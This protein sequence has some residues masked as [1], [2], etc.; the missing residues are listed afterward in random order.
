MERGEK[1]IAFTVRSIWSFNVISTERPNPN[2][3][4]WIVRYS[5]LDNFNV[6]LPDDVCRGL[7]ASE[8]FE[9]NLWPGFPFLGT[10]VLSS[11]S[12]TDTFVPPP[13]PNPP[14]DGNGIQT[15]TIDHVKRTHSISIPYLGNSVAYSNIVYQRNQ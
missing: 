4:R 7:R 15:I 8:I 11:N 2:E 10:P 3:Y 1:E 9:H 14:G 5:L 12:L 6:A 13:V